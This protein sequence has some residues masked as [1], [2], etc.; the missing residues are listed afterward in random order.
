MAKLLK[1]STA[2]RRSSSVNTAELSLAG[3]A[4]AIEDY[5]EHGLFSFQTSIPEN[6]EDYVVDA[7]E[8][9]GYRVSYPEYAGLI[10][11]SQDVTKPRGVLGRF[12]ERLRILSP[13]QLPFVPQVMNNGYVSLMVSW[14]PEELTEE[15]P[16]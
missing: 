14:A 3:I 2:R 16:F 15:Y 11:W 9:A 7:L 4:A 1:A 8:K 6:E 5:T 10:E 13:R 12:L